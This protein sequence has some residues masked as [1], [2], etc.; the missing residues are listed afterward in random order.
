M[1][2]SGRIICGY[3]DLEYGHVDGSGT[4][5]GMGFGEGDCADCKGNGAASAD[6]Q[7]E[8]YG[9]I[10]DLEVGWYHESGTAWTSDNFEGPITSGKHVAYTDYVWYQS[11]RA[12]RSELFAG[13]YCSP[14]GVFYTR[15]EAEANLA[16]WILK[17]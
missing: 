4:C 8:W 15:E 3:S 17:C 13:S 11:G 9:D 1:K 5:D 2:F 10:D 6:R 16:L 12:L 14:F 7:G